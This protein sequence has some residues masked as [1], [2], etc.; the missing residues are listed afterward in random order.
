MRKKLVLLTGASLAGLAAISWSILGS[1]VE[2]PD[3]ELIS[4][5]GNIEVRSYAPMIVA[6][7]TVEGD[8]EEAIQ[9][10]FR[11]IADYIFG[12]NRSSEKVAMTAP[13]TQQSSH[14]IA[15]TAPVTQQ[16]EGNLWKVRFV[17]PSKYRME[18]LPQPVNS[19]VVLVQV[20]EKRFAAIR[21]SG[22]AGKTSLKNHEAELR[23]FIS[24]NGLESANSPEYAFYNPPWTLPFMRRNEIL[25]ELAS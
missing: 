20:P 5:T 23:Q 18:S 9:R 17:M 4:K 3:Y 14:S 7:T 2:T 22:L 12:S 15:M 19:Q 11:I 16:A 6:E 8:R 1:D 10:G 13:V 21:F 25:V 24:E